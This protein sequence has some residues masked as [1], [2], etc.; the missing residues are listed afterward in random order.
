MKQEPGG[1]TKRKV[2]EEPLRL[3]ERLWRTRGRYS[4][5]AGGTLL[6]ISAIFLIL[7]YV[8]RY[9]VFEVTSIVALLLGVVLVFTGIEPYVKVSVADRAVTSS[10]VALGKVLAYSRIKSE[11]L[12][13]P[14]AEGKSVGKI[15]IPT[16]S[17]NTLPTLEEIMK[18][19]RR[20]PKKGLLL[21]STGSALLRLYEEDLGDLRNIDL[22]YLMEWLPRVLVDGLQMAER[23]EVNREAEKIRVRFTASAFRYLCQDTEVAKTICETTGCP[24]CGSVA[25]AIAKTTSRVVYYIGCGYDPLTQVMD[26]TYRLGPTLESL[27]QSEG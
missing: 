19:R 15:F 25:E 6:A 10:L 26:A 4:R 23:V 7:A 14:P 5:V 9:I 11:A 21:P 1:R 2:E 20:I 17:E 24:I 12:Y 8:T 13:L 18:E 3:R 22:D 16:R 27:R